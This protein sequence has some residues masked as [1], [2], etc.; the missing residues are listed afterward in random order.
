M[1]RVSTIEFVTRPLDENRP[2]ILQV[3]PVVD[4]EEFTASVTAFEEAH[5]F[6]PSGGYSGIVPGH[7]RLG[8]LDRYLLGETE[9]F[10]SS[11]TIDLL[12]C[13]C[14]E[15]GCWPLLAAVAVTEEHVTWSSF[16]QP[17]RPERDYSEFGPFAFE[18]DTYREAS[19]RATELAP[20][21]W[22]C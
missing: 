11:G 6:D 15:W 12:G 21:A 19:G 7:I 5:G 18:A 17:H 3:I 4:G 8:P 9:V 1:P 2:R 16:S 20:R 22:D 10:P 13:S 14:G